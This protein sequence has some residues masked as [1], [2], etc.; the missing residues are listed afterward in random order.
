[1]RYF[2]GSGLRWAEENNDRHALRTSHS[3]GHVKQIVYS[4]RIHNI[5]HL[6]QQIGEAAAT[7]TPD[8]PGRVWHEM[9]Y[10]LDVCRATNRPPH[11]TSI[12]RWR[13]LFEL[14]FNEIHI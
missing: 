7:V 10:R 4:V 12:I 8:V 11:R 2:Y 1:M 14:F 13:N 9:E 6:K 5:Q 3:W